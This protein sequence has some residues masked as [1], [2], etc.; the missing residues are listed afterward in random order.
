M[1]FSHR[2]LIATFLCDAPA[3]CGAFA[4]KRRVVAATQADGCTDER[5]RPGRV[6]RR[7]PGKQLLVP[8]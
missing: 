2:W 1:S 5:A 3:R 8:N 6:V 7:G 4:D